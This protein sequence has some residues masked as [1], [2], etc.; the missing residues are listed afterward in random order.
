MTHRK[1]R[2]LTRLLGSHL[3]ARGI[4]E[5]IW[6]ACY[7]SGD[8]YLGTPH[9]IETLVGWEGEAGHLTRSLAEVGAPEGGAGFIEPVRQDP[10]ET[11]TTY[12]VHDLWHHA[13][14]Y[15]Q[16]RHRREL[17]RQQRVAPNPAD[18]RQTAPNGGQDPP[19]SDR[20]IEKEIT[21]APAPARAPARAQ[22]DAP[23][24]TNHD[25]CYPATAACR[26]GICLPMWLG[27]TWVR[28]VGDPLK[29]DAE[30]QAAVRD[31]LLGLAPGPVG[32]TPKVFWEG[33]WAK[34]HAGK[35]HS[36]V[37]PAGPVVPGVDETQALLQKTRAERAAVLAADVAKAASGR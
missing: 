18:R 33:V 16:K 8:S 4:L 36:G 30:V 19:T 3:L 1:F 12:R 37:R 11:K 23:P 35:T 34:R 21:L 9:D 10:D 15:V 13:P 28:Q 2:R 29:G 20:Q 31:G 7:E 17:Q 6:D 26:R 32:V 24:L 5:V 22:G 27:A 14:D 25:R